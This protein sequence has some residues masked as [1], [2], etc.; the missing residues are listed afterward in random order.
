MSELDYLERTSV[1]SLLA[2]S[3]HPVVV[4][5]LHLLLLAVAKLPLAIAVV[6]LLLVVVALQLPPMPVVAVE[7]RWSLRLSWFQPTSPRC[8][9]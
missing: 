9:L 2:V 5:M 7:L 4:A 8:A 3:Q 1:A 6:E